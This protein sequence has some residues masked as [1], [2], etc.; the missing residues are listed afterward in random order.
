[1]TIA[2]EKA[3]W[4]AVATGELSSTFRLDTPSE[5]SRPHTMHS[6]LKRSS[7]R[8]RMVLIG[9]VVLAGP[10]ASCVSQGG[11]QLVSAHVVDLMKARETRQAPQFSRKADITTPR[12]ARVASPPAE[13][14][15]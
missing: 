12:P 10:A 14:A 1:V 5:G 7:T 15:N 11:P 9:P 3:F 13:I 2:V 4:G 8:R 6:K